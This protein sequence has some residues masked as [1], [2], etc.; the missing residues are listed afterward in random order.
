MTRPVSRAPHRHLI[1]FGPFS[2]IRPETFHGK[3]IG[4]HAANRTPLR[5]GP[6]N[7]SSTSAT[8]TTA[9]TNVSAKA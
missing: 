6:S 3:L 7:A 5:S 4:A 2:C 9:H 1:T 8:A